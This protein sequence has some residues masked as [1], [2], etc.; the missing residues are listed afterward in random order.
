MLHNLYRHALK[1]KQITFCQSIFVTTRGLFFSKVSLLK[2]FRESWFQVYILVL[3]MGAVIRISDND[4][5]NFSSL[6]W[7]VH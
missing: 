3:P 7:S 5:V 6:Y 1:P 4:N 2:R